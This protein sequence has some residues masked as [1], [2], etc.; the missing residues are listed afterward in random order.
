MLNT[1][2]IQTG[3]HMDKKE[4][5]RTYTGLRELICEIEEG[6]YDGW[7]LD[8]KYP[9]IVCEWLRNIGQGVYDDTRQIQR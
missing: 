1:Q 9:L 2:Y 7:G 5:F 6:K 8:K 4:A 3:G